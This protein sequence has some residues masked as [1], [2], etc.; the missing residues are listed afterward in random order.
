MRVFKLVGAALVV[1]S[2]TACGGGGGGGETGASTLSTTQENYLASS[3]SNSYNGFIWRLPTDTSTPIDGTHYFAATKYASNANPANGT[4]DINLTV[5]NLSKS[6]TN[7][8]TASLFTQRVLINGVIYVTNASSKTEVSFTDGLVRMQRYATDGV[9]KLPIRDFDEWSAPIP[10]SGTL[11]NSEAL[12]TYYNFAN[13][14]RSTN[15]DMSTQWRAG[16]SYVTR[17]QII[18][19][20]AIELLD[21]NTTTYDANVSPWSGTQT[22]IEDMFNY[23]TTTFGGVTWRGTTYQI[24]DGTIT[25]KQGARTWISSAPL[26]TST[27]P[28]TARTCVV[29]LNGKIYFGQIFEAGTRVRMLSN[30]DSTVILDDSIRFNADA[31]ESIRDAVKF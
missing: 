27:S 21:W 12:K 4:T 16:A 19:N 26:P 7:P 3:Y 11:A 23:V 1:A 6:L 30:T 20:E 13:T 2:L 22:T 24:D 17:K 9:T 28:T 5:D 14:T 8:P 10:L 25:T 18:T 31:V 15:L 29:E